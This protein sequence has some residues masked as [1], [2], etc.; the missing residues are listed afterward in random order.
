MNLR[1]QIFAATLAF[2]SALPAAVVAEGPDSL[3]IHHLDVGQ[4]DATLIVARAAGD[5]FEAVLIDG[6]NRSDGREIVLPYLRSLGL[7]RLDLV[8]ATHFHADHIGGI[9]EVIAGLKAP[10]PVFVRA[11]GNPAP[12]STIQAYELFLAAGC[13]P[14]A[15]AGLTLRERAR[16]FRP[17]Q[18]DSER[19]FAA[20][21]LDR[22]TGREP[23]EGR[24]I[25]LPGG[26]RLIAVAGNGCLIGR[27]GILTDCAP[28]AKMDENAGSLA[29]VLSVG[30]FDYFIGGDLGGGGAGGGHLVV[31]LETPLSRVLGS[32]EV[33]RL[34]HHGSATSSNQAF[35]A[36]LAPQ[37]AVISVGDADS[38]ARQY[39]HPRRAVLARL[40][41]LA[42][43]DILKRVFLTNG[44]DRSARAFMAARPLFDIAPG[45]VLVTSNGRHFTVNGQRR[46]T[47]GRA[48]LP[49]GAGPS[50][51]D[52][53]TL[54]TEG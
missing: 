10:P 30:S 15:E 3:E 37:V 34:S 16:R 52:V 4:G 45:T 40:A 2:A 46:P 17:D 36:A 39:R 43:D 38:R 51:T 54:E 14:V 47:D 32:V 20:A 8:V 12:P 50:G 41:T 22:L 42:Q 35:L 49:A 7:D 31:D 13:A 26:A 24:T 27:D 25:P 11:R 28:R 29:F 44:G 19:L 6:G 33:L 18:C 23:G 21:E 48:S 5:K 1:I 9:D 53:A